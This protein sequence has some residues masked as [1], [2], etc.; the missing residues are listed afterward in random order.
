L[1]DRA[2]GLKILIDEDLSPWVA[3]RLRVDK[4]VD[5]AHVRDRGSLGKTDREVLQLAFGEDRILVTANVI[6]FERL[7]RSSE[8]HGGIVVVMAGSLRRTEQLA[9]LCNVVDTL[10]AEFAAGR[11]MV[12]RVLRVPIEGANEFFDLPEPPP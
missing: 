4:L 7:A 8:I 9:V 12:N 3:Q 5:A 6:D 11:D 10:S 2:Q 1:G